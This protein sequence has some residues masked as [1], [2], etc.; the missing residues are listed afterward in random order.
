MP[1]SVTGELRSLLVVAAPLVLAQVAQNGM[2]FV[3]TVMVGRLGAGPLAG[4]ALGAV[5]FNF[6]YLL[7]MALVMAVSPVVAQAVGAG[8]HADG[9]R[10]LRHGLVLA[11]ALSL[12]VALLVA[13]LSPLL[14]LLRQEAGVVA[15][16]DEYLGAVAFGLPGALAF[17]ALRGFLEGNGQTRPIMFVAGAGVLVNA[18]LNELLIFGRLGLPAL[19]LVGA[20]VATAVTYSLMAVGAAL[21]VSCG[22]GSLRV[23]RG[24][25][26]EGRVLRELLALGWPMSLSL[27]FEAGLFSATALVMG[28]FGEGPLAG[29]Q[30]AM[31]TASL[32]FMVPLGVGIATSVRVGQAA[33]RG[34]RDGVRRAGWTGVAVA[35]SFMC[36]TAALYILAPRLVTAV[37]LDVNDPANAVVVGWAA[38]FLSLAGAFQLFDGVQVA[39][40][41]AL[42]GLKDTRA[43]ML[44]TLL[45][46]WIVG[47]PLGLICAFWLDLGPRGMWYGLIASLVLAAVLLSLRFRALTGRRSLAPAAQGA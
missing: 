46:Y 35:A 32:S 19:G 5:A 4:L 23:F 9:A 41:G 8:R 13:N 44:I 36:L 22:Y 34:D 38:T 17:V 28:V 39:A 16:A 27:G 45:S 7:T 30:V 29:H 31:Q 26:L 20:G 25:R 10:T 6:V 47:F 21:V 1:R 2:S 14:S 43:P 18:G 42:R 40:V 24:W 11:L 33:G 15:A 37:Y 3:D 12:P